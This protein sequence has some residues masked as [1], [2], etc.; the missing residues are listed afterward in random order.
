[1]KLGTAWSGLAWVVAGCQAGPSAAEAELVEQRVVVPSAGIPDEAGVQNANNNLSVARHDGRVFLAFRTAPNHFASRE[2]RMVVISSVDEQTWRFEGRFHLDRDLREP[3][4]LSTP[5]G[6]LL[7]FALLGT[8]P[9]AFEPGG[10]VGSRYA[11]PGDWS[12]PAP[13]FGDDFIPWRIRPSPDGG[14]E[15]VGYTGGAGVYDL[16][17]DPLRVVWLRSDDGLTWEPAVGQDGVVHEGGGSETDL[18]RL[19]DGGVVAVMRNEA[20]DEG[21]FGSKICTA[22][23]TDP[24]AWTC[25]HDPRKYDSPLMLRSGG[26]VWLVARRNV[27]ETGAYDVASPDLSFRE[28][29]LLNQVAYWQEPKRCALWEVDPEGPEVRWVMDLPSAG[30]TCFPDALEGD[31]PDRWTVYNY[32]SDPDLADLAWLDGQQGPTW[33]VRADLWLR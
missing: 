22:P 5:N 29:S 11:G 1:M 2:A 3:Q 27:T 20:G 16:S 17:G 23:G 30:D 26:R 4:L 28:R 14:F 12:E 15:V 32:T 25:V 10:T 24:G 33:I 8:N 31:A 7:Y 13:V 21:R 6:L 19:D 9:T 18:V